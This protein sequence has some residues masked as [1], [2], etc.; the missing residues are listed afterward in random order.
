MQTD[1]LVIGASATGINV[2]R[3]LKQRHPDAS[4]V[5]IDKESGCAR[6]SSGRNSGLLDAGFAWSPDSLKGRLCRSGNEELSSY[7]TEKGIPINRCG[8]L[9]VARDGDELSELDRLERRAEGSGIRLEQLSARQ[10]RELEPRARTHEQAL[11]FPDA[12]AVDPGSVVRQ[13]EQ[14]A[15][16]AGVRFLYEDS[17]LGRAGEE[18]IT[19]RGTVQAGFVVNCAGLNAD[20]I[21]RDFGVAENYRLLPLKYRYLES[22]GPPGSYR[23]HISAAADRLNG[24]WPG[25]SLL[26]GAD[27]R[28]KLGPAVQAAL[29]REQYRGAEGFQPFEMTRILALGVGQMFQ[30]GGEVCRLCA[31]RLTGSA[32]SRLI[33]AAQGLAEGISRNDYRDWSR[34]EI[35]PQLVN[36]ESHRL[37]QDFIIEQGSDSIHLLNSVSPVFTCSLPLARQICE[38]I[39]AR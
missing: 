26:L 7:C 28:A 14:D 22:A 9:V 35:Q 27:G 21:A 16:D 33:A 19:T 15:R 18:L 30:G 34:T 29:W 31:A 1:Y 10:A 12:A 39:G 2:A 3:E 13:M 17:Y 38:Q 36:L 25:V 6:H 11:L 8:E 24:P 32:R 5:V 20:R 37:E 23:T 4:V